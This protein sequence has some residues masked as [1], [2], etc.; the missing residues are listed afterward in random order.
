MSDNA[1]KRIFHIAKHLLVLWLIFLLQ[2]MV[3]SRMRLFGVAP[4]LLPLAVVSIGIFEGAHWGGLMGLYAG[5]LSDAA[6]SEH[7][8]FFTILLT[9]LGFLAGFLVSSVLS[10]GFPSYLLCSLLALILIALFQLFGLLVFYRQAPLAL[11]M[12][13]FYQSLYS[14]FFAL[15][16]YYVGRG[17]KKGHAHFHTQ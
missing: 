10:R 11:L 13:G 12:V 15:P 1:K 5:I 4:L 3:F 9:A 8:V 17:L 7:T 2:T 14:M 16:L 6:F